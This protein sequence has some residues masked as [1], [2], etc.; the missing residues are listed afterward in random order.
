MLLAFDMKEKIVFCLLM[1]KI[2]KFNTMLNVNSCI[3]WLVVNKLLFLRA[4]INE[5]GY[6]PALV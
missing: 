3:K 6:R 2:R 1:N 4:I 5:I